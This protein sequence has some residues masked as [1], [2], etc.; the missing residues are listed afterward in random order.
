MSYVC[1]G[2]TSGAVITDRPM[3]YIGAVVTLPGI[4]GLTLLK[5]AA[6]FTPWAPGYSVSHAVLNLVFFVPVY[7]AALYSIRHAHDREA[8]AILVIF[9]LCVSGFHAL[10]EI[11]FDHRFRLPA[12]PA[13]IMLATLPLGR[14]I[15]ATRHGHR[16]S[17][18]AVTVE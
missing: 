15:R 16:Q 11:D 6:F 18:P 8:V 9:I 10:Q 1:S 12:V 5:W 3:A 2:Y 14:P 17:G 13:M 4:V 7:V